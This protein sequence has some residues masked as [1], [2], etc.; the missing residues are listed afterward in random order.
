MRLRK[1]GVEEELNRW[2]RGSK[3]ELERGSVRWFIRGDKD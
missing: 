1:R 3:E 2:F